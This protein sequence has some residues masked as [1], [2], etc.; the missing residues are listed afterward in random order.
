MLDFSRDCVN[1]F[2]SG[3]KGVPNLQKETFPPPEAY[4]LPPAW[5]LPLKPRHGTFPCSG[6][7]APTDEGVKAGS[8]PMALV[9]GAEKLGATRSMWKPPI[10]LQ[11]NTEQGILHKSGNSI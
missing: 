8:M 4:E 7:T 5:G 11:P 9:S 6:T 3:F 2:H 10:S 1:N